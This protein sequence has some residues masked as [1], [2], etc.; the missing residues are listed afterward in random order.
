MGKFGNGAMFW[1]KKIGYSNIIFFGL[2]SWA[3][4]A[5]YLNNNLVFKINIRI[6]HIME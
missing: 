3:I 4:V 5:K 1:S 6:S 2:L